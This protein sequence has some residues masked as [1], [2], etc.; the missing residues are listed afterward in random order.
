M[1]LDMEDVGLFAG[2][3]GNASYFINNRLRITGHVRASYFYNPLPSFNLTIPDIVF[4]DNFRFP[5]Q[6]EFN[7]NAFFYQTVVEK[8]NFSGNVSFSYFLF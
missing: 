1:M 3:N 4:N 5:A 6:P 7:R 8:F 2:I